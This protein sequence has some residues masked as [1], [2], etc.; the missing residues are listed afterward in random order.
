MTNSTN[1]AKGSFR[2]HNYYTIPTGLPD[3]VLDSLY[4]QCQGFEADM[5]PSTVLATSGGSAGID[6]S[7]RIS[8]TYWIPTDHWI[9]N[10]MAYMI[11][12][13][14]DSLFK[15]DLTNWAEKI[16]YTVYDGKGS[17]Y[18]WHHDTAMS[19]YQTDKIRKLSISLLLSDPDEYEG[20][21]FQLMLGTRMY[22]C[23][24]PKGTAIVFPSTLTHRVRPLKSGIR[25]S[26]VGWYGGPSWR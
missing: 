23:K 6:E 11:K 3:E 12:E 7:I 14:N 8:K 1:L 5:K 19:S 10:V 20:G 21:E 17:N 4:K 9:A 2:I 26:L 13:A 18:G 15:V 22:S 25:R 24:F 16:Q